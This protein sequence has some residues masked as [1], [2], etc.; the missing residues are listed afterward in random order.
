M[1]LAGE[2]SNTFPLLLKLL[3]IRCHSWPAGT[4]V[5]EDCHYPLLPPNIYFGGR[6]TA[7]PTNASSSN[8]TLHIAFLALFVIGKR[9]A[10]AFAFHDLSVLLLCIQHLISSSTT[11]N[12]AAL[13]EFFCLFATFQQLVAGLAM[14]AFSCMCASIRVLNAGIVGSFQLTH[15]FLQPCVS[16]PGQNDK[17]HSIL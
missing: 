16:T 9:T 12:L 17:A 4:Q 8:V 2:D 3:R 5:G 11:I 15:F 13:P 6:A 10:E 1:E 7:P 14:V